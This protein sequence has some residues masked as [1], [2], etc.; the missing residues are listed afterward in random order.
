[1]LVGDRKLIGVA[2]VRRFG[3]VA[4]VGG[5][6]R[7]CDPV[8]QGACLAG[9]TALRAERAA[10]LAAC[11]SD[12]ATLGRPHAFEQFPAALVAALAARWAIALAPGELTAAERDRAAQLTAGRYAQ[13]DWTFRT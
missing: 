3:A 1:V 2:Q 6:Y 4:Y 10:Q 7:T 9:V 11:T 12:L 8:E 13:E 5:L